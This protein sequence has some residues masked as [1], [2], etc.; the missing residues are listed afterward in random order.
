MTIVSPI[1]VPIIE[2]MA[3]RVSSPVLVGRAAELARLTAALERARAGTSAAMLVPGEAGVGKTRLVTEFVDWAR[4]DGATI[5]SGGCVDLGE[6]AVPYV[7]IAEALRGFVR[8]TSAEDLDALLGPARAELARLVPDLGPVETGGTSELP[9]GSAQG[10]LFELLLGLL[11][12]LAATGPVV[13]VVEDLHWSD[14]ST[15]DLLAFLVRNL[16]ESAVLLVLTYRADELHRRHPLLPFVAE[17]ERTGRVE[18]L[19]VDRLNPA[20]AATLLRAIAGRELDPKLVASILERSGGNAFFAEELLAAAGADGRTELPATLRDV[21]LARVAL[22]TEPTQEVLRLA[23]AAGRRVDP[24]VLSAAAELEDDAIYDALREAVGRQVLVSEAAA[25]TERYAFRHALLREAVYDDLLAGERTRLHTAF[26]ET[27]ESR[28]GGGAGNAAEIAWHWYAAHELP[29][30]LT[31]SIAAASAAEYGYAFPEAV[32][33]YERALELWDRVPDAET[34]A[35]CDRIELLA[36][37]GRVA[38]FHDPARAVA[39]LQAAIRLVDAAADPVRAALLHERLG[40]YAWMAGQ[41]TLSLEAYRTAVELIPADPP[42]QAR[43]RAVAGYA[44]I[45]MLGGRFEASLANAE[46]ALATARAVGDRQIEGHALNTRGH[47]RAMA[48]DVD[49]G[50]ADMQAAL[51]IAEEVGVVDDIGRAQANWTWL[52]QHAG[53]YEESI[54]L[55]RQGIEMANRL[56]IRRVFGAHLLCG[57]ADDFYRLGRWDES[58]AAAWQAEEIGPLGINRIL[59]DEVIGRLAVAQGRFEEAAS[60]LEPLAPRADRAADIQFVSPVRASLAE[61][62]LWQGRADDA[63]AHVTSALEQIDFSPEVRLGELYVL[64]VRAHADRAEIARARRRG[65]E[66]AAALEAG[67]ALLEALR[68]R[69]ADTVAHRPVFARISEAWLRLAEAEGTRLRRSPDP[70]AWDA[71]AEA[72]DALGWPYPSAYA[73]WR[74]AEARLAARGDRAAAATALRA[75]RDIGERLGAAPLLAEIGSLA[76]RARIPLGEAEDLPQDDTAPDA[77]VELG[78][79]AREREVLG[80]VA[81][82]RTNRQIADALFISEN[83]AGVHVSNILGK[84]GV[85]GRGEAAAVAY[86]LGL[87][88]PVEDAG[89]S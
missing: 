89:A 79:T 30:A 68:A 29:R 56:G 2:R 57:L 16:R 17:L 31:W 63:A 62:A 25:G 45:L 67:S 27:L 82:G 72:W 34:R 8:T 26:A 47:D 41:G 43:A 65:D 50:A 55:A 28:A 21:L 4:S 22:L 20:D 35:G 54:A 32:V 46:E 64:G 14:Q 42:S 59:T 87:V 12:R 9:S 49:G 53:R 61:L 84:L 13:L 51:A 39:H 33:E 11:D 15:R 76:A 10:R 36:R 73:R 66:E 74:A 52:M 81:L 78:L 24:A 37:L 58:A 19:D 5:L 23:S 1:P 18:R 44:Q 77:A 60:R 86:R 75:A 85:G 3:V 88:A 71:S 6:S 7:P 48:G 40:R 83:T 38:M 69:H 70:V 80:L